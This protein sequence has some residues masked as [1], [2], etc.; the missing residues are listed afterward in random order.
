MNMNYLFVAVISLLLTNVA[1]AESR[2]AILTGGNCN[3][4]GAE[5]LQN[6]MKSDMNHLG[7]ALRRHAWTVDIQY[8]SDPSGVA[9]AVAQGALPG[10]SSK[11]ELLD[12]LDRIIAAQPQKG[13]E[14]L[15][16]FMTHGSP[17]EGPGSAHAICMNDGSH[18]SM[19]DPDLSSRL[20]RLKTLGVRLG[21]TDSS[22]FGGGSRILEKYGACVISSQ[23]ENAPSPV[24]KDDRPVFKGTKA[25][26]M[27]VTTHLAQL[28]DLAKDHP[29]QYAAIDLNQNS[30]SEKG[31][32]SLTLEEVAM[33]MLINAEAQAQGIATVAPYFTGD[34]LQGP[35]HDLETVAD[36]LTE[37]TP[38]LPGDAA[39]SLEDIFN[40]DVRKM[41]E[42][43]Q[44]KGK[45]AY[46][47]FTQ[48]VCS[49]SERLD[50]SFEK[51]MNDFDQVLN[52]PIRNKI[53]AYQTLTGVKDPEN[54]K[55][56]YS[57]FAQLRARYGR[58]VSELQSL[59]KMDESPPPADSSDI[60]A[61]LKVHYQVLNKIS[62]I[63]N[64]QSELEKASQG[65]F[66]DW[67]LNR[68]YVYLR[69]RPELLPT[70]RHRS[71][72]MDF[73]LN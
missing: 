42:P 22:C 32:G 68:A 62:E 58:A 2:Y 72:C 30:D 50:S 63:L 51:W 40:A 10:K 5:A 35:E 52:G 53:R 38:G 28:L 39:F 46:G 41:A 67:N 60:E 20:Q 48:A 44:K 25:S 13:S 71:P 1:S 19:D 64:L 3:K 18:L 56:T 70:E 29:D 65:V 57:S 36:G 23:S 33:S 37:F 55:K 15:L 24:V 14:L 34:P 43:M 26:Y 4:E 61:G 31:D 66:R 11:K 73:K 7:I 49:M 54:T 16:A 8:S 6:I 59:Q 9:P 45:S 21:V 27:G 17:A 47:D 12:S 69:Q